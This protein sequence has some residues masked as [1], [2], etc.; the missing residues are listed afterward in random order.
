MTKLRYQQGC[1]AGSQDRGNASSP[2]D[3]AWN[4]NFNNG[5]VNWNNQNNE[6]F[7]RAVRV[8]ECH[9]SVS[10]QALHTAWRHARAGKKPSANQLNFDVRWMDG[11]LRLQR[12][13]NDCS[14]EPKPPTCFV[15]KQ[16]KAREIHAPDFSDRVIHHWLVPQLEAI[17][18]RRFAFDSFSNRVGKGTH[19][20]VDRL[21]SYVRQVASGQGGGWYLQLDIHNFFNSI[22]RAT[23]YS[24]LSKRARRYHLP[25]IAQR[26]MH[27][28]LRRS[29]VERAHY[30]CRPS[31][32]ELVP[33]HK[34]L[35]N[36]APG[37]G[38]A[39]GNLSSQFFANVY[40][41]VLDQFVKHDLKVKRYVRYVDDFVL[42]HS[43][44]EQLLE[45]QH[46]IESF[47]G[48]RLRLRLK[49]DIKLQPL[50][51]GIDFLGYVIFPRH[52]LVRC[53]VVQHARQKLY[54]WQRNCPSQD[55]RRAARD[56]LAQLASIW[57][58]YTGHFSHANAGRLVADF[59]HRFIWLRS[60]LLR[61]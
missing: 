42:V 10:L 28:L 4:V 2:S 32:R 43:D 25:V 40:L 54:Q 55:P 51:V 53:R 6:C 16:P 23:L 60:A 30:L 15:A 37:C 47:I 49:D 8:G 18:E 13:L 35:A 22:H 14:W 46:R 44:R 36:A 34:R 50:T 39:I 11:L 31:E 29:P 20:A 24:M 9:D 1:S 26:A 41:D 17:Y 59:H 38:I 45:W 5:N 12:E 56:R 52:T 61:A 48:S 57:S 21:R 3:Y 58:S 27:A 19:A 7:V 33:P